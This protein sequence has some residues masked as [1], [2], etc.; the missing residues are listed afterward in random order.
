MSG[1]TGDHVAIACFTIYFR[2]FSRFPILLELPYNQ[3]RETNLISITILNYFN[4]PFPR[5]YVVYLL[6]RI[7]IH[8]YYCIIFMQFVYIIC[9]SLLIGHNQWNSHSHSPRLSECILLSANVRSP[10]YWS[11]VENRR[12]LQNQSC[13]SVHATINPCVCNGFSQKLL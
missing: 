7:G 6:Q 3:K 8:D 10:A 12:G 11:P 5:I 9:S 1:L 2:K 13:T 4:V